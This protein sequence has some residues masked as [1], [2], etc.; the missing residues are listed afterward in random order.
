MK[1]S[2][3]KTSKSL[4]KSDIWVAKGTQEGTKGTPKEHT[5]NQRKPKWTQG[6]PKRTQEA[7]C[8]KSVILSAKNK[9]GPRGP[10]GD[11]MTPKGEPRGSKEGKSGLASR[12]NC[13][14]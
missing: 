4:S 9:G 13:I 7:K 8:I 11:P 14:S 2:R 1:G 5:R 3:K 10:K 12:P 6:D